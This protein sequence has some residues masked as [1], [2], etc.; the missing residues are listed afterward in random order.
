MDDWMSIITPLQIKMQSYTLNY[1]KQLRE[2]ASTFVAYVQSCKI[3]GP[4][5]KG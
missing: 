2:G 4:R 1:V 5:W 3:I